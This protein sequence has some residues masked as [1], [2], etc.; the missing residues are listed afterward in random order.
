MLCKNCTGIICFLINI[1]GPSTEDVLAPCTDCILSLSFSLSLYFFHP[2]SLWQPIE[3]FVFFNEIWHSDRG[4]SPQ[5]S[6]QFWVHDIQAAS[7]TSRV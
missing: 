7:V 5:P 4:Q 6:D 2:R 3:H 1:R